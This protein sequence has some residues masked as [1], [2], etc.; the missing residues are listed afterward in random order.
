MYIKR[1]LQILIDSGST[2][3][4]LDLDA[5]K[6]LGCKLEPI[7][8]MSVTA[9]GGSEIASLYICKGFTWNLQQCTFTCDV[10]VLPIVCC[11]LIQKLFGILL[12]C[13]W[14]LMSMAINVC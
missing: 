10:Y 3:N 1:L 2:H 12:N 11:D 5:A 14:N 7:K 8:P 6:R 9:C 4:F 13:R